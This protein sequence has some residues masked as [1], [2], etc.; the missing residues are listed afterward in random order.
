MNRSES[1]WH[2]Q[3]QERPPAVR[4]AAA[5]VGIMMA[6][7]LVFTVSL[8]HLS[9]TQLQDS[10][11]REYLHFRPLINVVPSDGSDS[12]ALTPD[13]SQYQA[14]LSA[15][16][17]HLALELAYFNLV[18]LILAGAA[19]YQLARRTLRPIEDAL[20]A[21]TRFA[22]DASHELRTPLTAMQAEI[23]VALRNT[24]LSGADARK[25]LGSNLEEVGK[26]KV[27]SDGLLRLARGTGE[28]PVGPVA[29]AEVISQA[30][31]RLAKAAA[32]K[33]VEVTSSGGTVEALGDTP[34]LIE[35]IAILLDNAIKFS[36]AGSPV[37]IQLARQGRQAVVTV[38][39]HGPG[40]AD[41]D[42]P[43]IFERFYRADR[44][45]G[46]YELESTGMTQSVPGSGL[47]L[48]IARQI[49]EEA[50][51]TLTVEST[52]GVGSCFTVR[53]PLTTARRDGKQ[54]L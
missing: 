50:G 36:P 37:A 11:R 23:E 51:G 4:L 10:L 40:I 1:F 14:E 19:S 38:S 9:S 5:Y 25:L 22:G 8:Y 29:L 26:L 44:A 42:L 20:E 52:L 21:Q 2:K 48:A 27:L 46:R 16:R 49:V 18:I 34:T 47:G 3:W 53:L 6:I 15:G 24:K 28:L 43:H 7:S 41:Q 45:H 31:Q 30:V 35:L 54:F 33:K 17:R 12:F 13:A 32:A 39:D